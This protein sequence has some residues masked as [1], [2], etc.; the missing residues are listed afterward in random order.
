MCFLL[1]AGLVHLSV[2]AEGK[3]A[4]AAASGT[5]SVAG[6]SEQQS[7][8]ARFRRVR[9]SVVTLPWSDEGR[10]LKTVLDRLDEAGSADHADIVCLPMECV[11]TDGEAIPGPISQALAEKARQYPIGRSCIITAATAWRPP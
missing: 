3:A 4:D 5:E 7:V 1:F 8:P 9:A 6:V 2:L 11:K 10:T